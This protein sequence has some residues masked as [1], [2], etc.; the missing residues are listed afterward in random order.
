[1]RNWTSLNGKV[2]EAAFVRYENASHSVVIQKR[3]GTIIKVNR[4]SLCD[5]DWLYVMNHDMSIFEFWLPIGEC[6]TS[7]GVVCPPIDG[8]SINKQ[9][10][11]AAGGPKKVLAFSASN[12]GMMRIVYDNNLPIIIP[13]N[14]DFFAY[15]SHSSSRREGYFRKGQYQNMASGGIVYEWNRIPPP[16]NRGPSRQ[17]I[18][19]TPELVLHLDLNW[20]IA[21]SYD[22]NGRSWEYPQKELGNWRSFLFDKQGIQEVANLSAVCCSIQHSFNSIPRYERISKRISAMNQGIPSDIASSIGKNSEKKFLGSGSG[23]F[24]TTD[25]YFLT[26]YHVVQGGS[27]IQLR[28]VS[29]NTNAKVLLVDPAIDLALLKADGNGFVPLPFAKETE[30]SLG[31]DI[32]TIGFP[33]PEIQGFNPKLTKGVISG[34]S[35]IRDTPVLYQIDA[36]IQPGNSGGPV[37]NS[38][39][40]MIGMIVSSL[41]EDLVVDRHGAVP[42]NV[43]YAIKKKYILDFVSKNSDCFKKITDSS[44]FSKGDV[45]LTKVVKSVNNSCAM[46]VMFE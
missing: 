16:R 44:A 17:N 22:E 20:Q 30:S 6:H 2:T 13:F 4:D 43:N 28:T 41:R 18:F 26:N 40:E 37:V 36:A 34:L 32:F 24:V 15:V 39:G 3:D 19:G 45:S 11:K 10:T 1:M 38:R 21:V 7:I 29:G 25:G 12:T 35:G 23:F 42:Q 14:Q 5:D 9:T 8:K 27:L 46:V 31:E 33:M